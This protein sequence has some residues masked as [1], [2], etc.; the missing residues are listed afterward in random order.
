MPGW[1][2]Q[3]GYFVHGMGTYSAEYIHYHL[4]PFFDVLMAGVGKLYHPGLPPNDDG[5]LSWSDP[6]RYSQGGETPILPGQSPDSIPDSTA[7]TPDDDWGAEMLTAGCLLVSTAA[8][9]ARSTALR[10][11]MTPC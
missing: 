10:A 11:P 8:P 1:F 5:E 2:K 3:H 4:S 6:S 9:T 7:A